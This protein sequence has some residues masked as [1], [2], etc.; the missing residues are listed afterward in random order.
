MGEQRKKG[1]LCRMH[2]NDGDESTEE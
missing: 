1:E 2:T